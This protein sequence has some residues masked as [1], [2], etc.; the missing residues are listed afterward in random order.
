MGAFY[1]FCTKKEQIRYKNMFESIWTKKENIDKD[2]M[3]VLNM[4]AAEECICSEFPIVCEKR[5]KVWAIWFQDEDDYLLTDPVNL[6]NS[7]FEDNN[8][9][10]L[11]AF[12]DNSQEEHEGHFEVTVQK[13]NHCISWRIYQT[14]AKHMRQML[15]TYDEYIGKIK[16]C[17]DELYSVWKEG[18]PI[19]YK[20]ADAELES[21]LICKKQLA[22]KA[23][24]PTHYQLMTKNIN[25]ETFTFQPIKGNYT[26]HYEIGIGDRKFK[27]F[28]THW[29]N[30]MELI[31]H[32]FESYIW[33]MKTSI[34]LNFDGLPTT[35]KLSH[36]RIMDKYEDT[37]DGY[38]YSYKDYVLV[39]IIPNGF[40]NMPIIIGYCDEKKTIKAL[41]EGLLF[42]ASMHPEDGNERDQ[43]D[44]PSTLVAYNRYKSP[45]IES[46]LKGEKDELNTYKNRQIR[47]DEILRIEPDVNSYIWDKEDVGGSVNCYDDKDGNPIEM[48]EFDK[49]AYEIEAIVIASETGEPYEKDWDDYHRRGLELAKKLREVLPITTDLWYEAPF[50]DKS[51]TI[52]H[53]MLIL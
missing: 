53:R 49:W 18:N 30:N 26:E 1:Y 2:N 10:L 19:A 24:L 51:G 38:R 23:V 39:E 50:E 7:I 37:G 3:E 5:E 42:M 11:N 32:Q 16:T 9:Y 28:M 43:S 29:D 33:G 13:W 35:L 40:V 47:I 52:P 21:I 44:R 15:F 34:E 6:V 14:Q 20:K 36:H 46:F 25:L 22:I 12:T 4:I 8:Y 27:T 17:I 45:L 41:Y 31:R 48:E